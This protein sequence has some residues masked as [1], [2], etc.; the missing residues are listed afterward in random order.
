MFRK[1]T[2]AVLVIINPDTNKPW[3]PQVDDDVTQDTWVKGKEGWQM[4][5]SKP[6]RTKRHRPGPESR[7][8]EQR[9]GNS[10]LQRQRDGLVWRHCASLRPGRGKGFLA[11]SLTGGGHLP[12]ARF[13]LTRREGRTDLLPQRLCRSPER[14][15][16]LRFAGMGGKVGEC[17][18]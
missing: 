7:K 8:W 9:S 10:A 3:P 11:Q 4:T 17:F 18:E 6:V 14:G 12:G 16:L 1:R 5:Y 2:N 13:S 15:G